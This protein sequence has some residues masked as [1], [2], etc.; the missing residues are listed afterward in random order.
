M[1]NRTAAA[2]GFEP[3][4]YE[5][6]CTKLNFLMSA[7]ALFRTS[8]LRGLVHVGEG[9][10]TDR[11]VSFRTSSLRGLV[12]EMLGDECEIEI[13]SNLVPTRFGAHASAAEY[14]AINVSNLVPTRFGA[15]GIVSIWEGMACF[16]PRPYEVWC[17][18]G[19]VP[20]SPERA[21]RTSS[22]RGL[23]H[24]P[25]EN[26]PR[27]SVE[28]S[29]LVPT[30]FGAPML[31]R[32]ATL[33]AGFEPRPYEVWC[34]SATLRSR[35]LRPVSNLVP[36]RFGARVS[37]ARMFKRYR[38][39]TSSLRGLVHLAL[40]VD[41]WVRLRFRTSSLRGLVHYVGKSQA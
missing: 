34:T 38:F 39:R 11:S 12:H 4:P 29:N 27:Y 2:L 25:E 20:S 22:L 8:S 32:C 28:V 6:W 15:P 16:E 35:A 24:A 17:T 3:R 18:D 19:V 26:L 7:L 13:V 37:P 5:V 1:L 31:A 10:E 9:E 21:F 23:V 14:D 41:D 33:D 36:T 30:R 40:K